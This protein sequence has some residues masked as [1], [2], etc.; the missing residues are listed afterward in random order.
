MP[1]D[2]RP[3]QKST[4]TG[5]FFKRLVFDETSLDAD[6]RR[7]DARTPVVGEV[8]VVVLGPTGAPIGRTRVFVRDLSK[9]GCAIWSRTRIAPGTNLIIHFPAASGRPPLARAALACHCR[10]Q[11]GAGFAIGCRFATE[12]QTGAA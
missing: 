9:D 5:S 4:K 7:A 6:N 2:P 3:N 11:E 8:D 10:G 1:T 12:S